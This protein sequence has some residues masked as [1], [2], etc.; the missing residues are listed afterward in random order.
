MLR[1]A[2]DTNS[3]VKQ[4]QKFGA[5]LGAQVGTDIDHLR[6]RALEL[7]VIG[8]AGIDQDAIVEI[9]GEIKRIAFRRPGFLHEIDIDLGIEARAHRP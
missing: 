7:H 8:D 5:Q 9:A 1:C 6:E 2:R 3:S 4:F